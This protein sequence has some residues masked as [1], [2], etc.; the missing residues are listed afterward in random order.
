MRY[1]VRIAAE[2]YI[3]PCITRKLYVDHDAVF[4]LYFCFGDSRSCKQHFILLVLI[5]YDFRCAVELRYFFGLT[6]L[7]VQLGFG[8]SDFDCVQFG[9]AFVF[10]GGVFIDGFKYHRSDR[11]YYDYNGYCNDDSKDQ[12]IVHYLP[13]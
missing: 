1:I 7:R 12:C 6:E 8:H 13:R 10:F 3:N 11:A 4:D 9:C 5:R 2:L